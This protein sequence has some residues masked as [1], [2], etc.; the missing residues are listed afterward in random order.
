MKLDVE[1]LAARWVLDLIPSDEWP[2]AAAQ[3]LTDGRDGPA[4]R[5]LAGER[6]PI[7]SEISRVVERALVELGAPKLSRRDAAMALAKRLAAQIVEGSMEP[8]DGAKRIWQL[9]F[10]VADVG[11]ALDPFVYWASE[12]EDASDAQRSRFCIDAI[13]ASARELVGP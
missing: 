9:Q 10:L 7:R 13:L 4:L 1:Q 12:L 3:A 11:H 6:D 5:E 8:Y 2:E